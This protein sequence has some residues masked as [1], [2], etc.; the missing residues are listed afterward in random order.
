MLIIGT[1]S[2]SGYP[3][4]WREC[5]MLSK[6]KP[7]QAATLAAGALLSLLLSG[8]AGEGTPTYKSYKGTVNPEAIKVGAPQSM[9]EEAIVSFVQDPSVTYGTATQFLSR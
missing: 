7:F 6:T 2:Q 8:C 1:P 3:G 4:L 9:F 5:S